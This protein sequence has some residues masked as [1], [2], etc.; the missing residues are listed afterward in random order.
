MY[1]AGR[2]E[3]D[4]SVGWYEGEIGFFDFYIIPLARKLETCGIFG[5]SS[6]EYLGYAEN[7]RME[8][9]TKGT[10]LVE[11]YLQRFYAEHETEIGQEVAPSRD[12]VDDTDVKESQVILEDS[13]SIL[14]SNVMEC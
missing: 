10:E 4:P 3:K 2:L 5:V 6:S 12:A 9:V 8:W 11:G 1:L 13:L 7:N 14:L